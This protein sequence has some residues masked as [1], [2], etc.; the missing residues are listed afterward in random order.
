MTK[1]EQEVIN[2]ALAWRRI[3]LM[4]KRIGQAPPGVEA[5]ALS[6]LADAVDAVEKKRAKAAAKVIAE[7]IAGIRQLES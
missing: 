4:E 2:R 3:K 5:N 1:A 7:W 6:K